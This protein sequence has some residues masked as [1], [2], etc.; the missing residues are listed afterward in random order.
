[1]PHL[2]T[3][4]RRLR[5]AGLSLVELMVGITI[6]LIVVAAAS[7]MM[8]NQV[9]ENSRLLVETQLQQDLR[10]AAE[11][12]LRDIRRAGYN[13]NASLSVWS[14]SN[15]SPISNIYAPT[16]APSFA[17]TTTASQFF[18]AYY[19]KTGGATMP[20]S[21]ESFGFMR[22]TEADSS[23]GIL[24]AVNGTAFDSTAAPQS[25]QFPAGTTP[26]R[27]PLTD[28]ALINVT[29]FQISIVP[30]TVSLGTYANPPKVCTPGAPDCPCLIVR[31]VDISIT[32]TSVRDPLVQR[33]INVSGRIR[34]DQILPSC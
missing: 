1:M 7:L 33:T 21:N 18:Y 2:M 23:V 8:T 25:F 11:L 5:Q 28:P 29:N 26:A 14:P 27:Q 4:R 16:F 12:M 10:A 31:R 20:A 9:S 17:R 34:N 15:T 6:G 24:Y 22:D 19:N 32:A 13:N 3:T 30:Q